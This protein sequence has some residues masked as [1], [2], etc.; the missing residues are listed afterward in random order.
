MS[1]RLCR[2]GQ[3][4]P[5]YSWCAPEAVDKRQDF[6]LKPGATV[7][8][9]AWRNAQMRD[10]RPDVVLQNLNEDILACIENLQDGAY[11]A[12]L[13]SAADINQRNLDLSGLEVSELNP[14]EFV[15][16]PAQGVLAW[17]THR[18]DLSTRRILKQLHHPNVSACTNVERRVL[19]LLGGDAHLLLGVLVECDAGGVFHAF[20]ACAREGRLRRTRL[21]QSTR[22]ELA[23]QVVKSL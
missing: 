1:S 19:H 14:R 17:Q 23:E 21:S 8:A 7:G 5:T 2:N 20:A 22:I 10:F 12:V 9:T 16:R 3:T 4:R 15:P 11:D 13:L 6:G 18:D